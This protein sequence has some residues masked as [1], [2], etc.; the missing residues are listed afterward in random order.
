[1]SDDSEIIQRVD[2]LLIRL[3]EIYEE[4]INLG[5]YKKYSY[6]EFVNICK[7]LYI[8]SEK[9]GEASRKIWNSDNGH[10]G[11]FIRIMELE[12]AFFKKINTY[13]I[14]P[15]LL[16]LSYKP[17]IRD[18]AE[19]IIMSYKEEYCPIPGLHD[20]CRNILEYLKVI[21]HNIEGLKKINKEI[22]LKFLSNYGIK[23]EKYRRFKKSLS[24]NIKAPDKKTILRN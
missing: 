3:N 6:H 9:F 19:D 14:I 11:L 7:E 16:V 22:E 15:R 24:I 10:L 8:L 23:E 1:M 4:V 18:V 2:T 20:W 17:K 13:N 12:N 5:I 21:E